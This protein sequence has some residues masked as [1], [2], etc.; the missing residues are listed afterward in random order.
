MVQI[1]AIYLFLVAEVAL[2]LVVGAL[3]AVVVVVRG[4]RR[5]QR[6]TAALLARVKAQ[7]QTDGPTLT[8]WLGTHHDL[9]GTDLEHTTRRLQQ[10]QTALYRAVLDAL[11]TRDEPHFLAIAEAVER[12]TAGYRGLPQSGPGGI[13]P[14]E[15][16]H[17]RRE[18]ARLA[19]E[20]AITKQTM[21]RMLKE[22]A[23]GLHPAGALPSPEDD[24]DSG[25]DLFE[26]V[27][28]DEDDADDLDRDLF[29]LPAEPMETPDPE[30]G[31]PSSPGTSEPPEAAAPGAPPGAA[32]ML[33]QE[34]F[35]LPPEP[36]DGGDDP[37]PD[38]D[39]DEGASP[40]PARNDR[41]G[42]DTNLEDLVAGELGDLAARRDPPL[43]DQPEESG[44]MAPPGR[45]GEG[46]T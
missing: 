18:N 3:I 26:A 44:R 32:P 6:A 9:R 34:R 13:N 11:A 15:V 35:D 25:D 27:A 43:R 28:R 42:L 20:L 23:A 30:G 29:D 46:P 17:L 39:T 31:S 14:A 41:T 22:Y 19:E 45:S 21:D 12:L 7:H 10:E 1:D 2:V 8:G 33:D 37:A 16:E 24:L 40:A 4:R 5:E 36:R 38:V